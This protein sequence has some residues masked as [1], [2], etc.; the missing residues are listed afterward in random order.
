MRIKLFFKILIVGF[1][2][3]GVWGIFILPNLIKV[4]RLSLQINNLPPSFKGVK[5]LHLTDFHSKKFGRKEKKV[6]KMVSELKPDFI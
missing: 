5:I 1:L 4:E 2:I 6:L 3:M